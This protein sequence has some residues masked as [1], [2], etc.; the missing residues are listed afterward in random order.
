[1]IL[2]LLPCAPLFGL[3][4]AYSIASLAVA[5]ALLSGC[6]SSFVQA[7]V[8]NHTG[9]AI[10]LFE[11]DYPSASF[12]AGELAPGKE[13]HY[14]FKVV[15]SGTSKVSWTTADEAEHTAQGPQL[16]EG[17]A[18]EMVITLSQKT[19]AWTQQIHQNK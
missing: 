2:K 14:R 18:G 3:R 13:F 19:A 10:H 4:F 9:G 1:M 11:V 12:G 8:V 7:T 5:G 17:D 16:D 6:H 15:G